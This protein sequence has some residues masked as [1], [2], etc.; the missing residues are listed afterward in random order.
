MSGAARGRTNENTDGEE[1]N[2]AEGGW[3]WEGGMT[4]KRAA[5]GSRTAGFLSHW[6]TLMKI[7]IKLCR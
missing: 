6:V 2:E 3:K 4:K 1:K 5:E 7:L